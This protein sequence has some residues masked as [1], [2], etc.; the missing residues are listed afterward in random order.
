MANQKTVD[1]IKSIGERSKRD[2]EQADKIIQTL[3]D[4]GYSYDEMI[5]VIRL[6]KKKFEAMQKQ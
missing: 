2:H 6:A 1:K 4:Y 5:P 3:K